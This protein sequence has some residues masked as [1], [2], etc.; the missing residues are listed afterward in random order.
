MKKIKLKGELIAEKDGQLV[1]D[2][3]GDNW[4]GYNFKENT[5]VNV[6]FQNLEKW[7]D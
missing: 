2:L 5:K 3:L 1:I 7:E 6:E 4:E